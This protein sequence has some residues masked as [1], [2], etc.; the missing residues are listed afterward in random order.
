LFTG[1]FFTNTPLEGDEKEISLENN[2]TKF[3]LEL[4]LYIFDFI[5]N[6]FSAQ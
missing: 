1:N 5:E 3:L 4:P 6:C 2:M